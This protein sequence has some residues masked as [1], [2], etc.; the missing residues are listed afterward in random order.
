LFLMAD[1]LGLEIFQ[2]KARGKKGK[3]ARKERGV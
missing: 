2:G 3:K 1:T